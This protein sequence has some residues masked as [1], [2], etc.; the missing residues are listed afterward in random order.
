MM[1]ITGVRQR[2]PILVA[3]V[4]TSSASANDGMYA[5]NWLDCDAV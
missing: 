5:Q 3:Y 4:L 1:N 2:I